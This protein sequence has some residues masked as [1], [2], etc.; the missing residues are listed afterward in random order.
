[1]RHANF[2][3]LKQKREIIEIE[4]YAHRCVRV[5][6]VGK[7]LK[8]QG[9]DLRYAFCSVLNREKTTPQPTGTESRKRAEN[10]SFFGYGF[11]CLLLFS[12]PFHRGYMAVFMTTGA[13][14][15]HTIL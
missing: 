15:N 7:G 12:I 1:M 13:R 6:G 10:T 11:L 3:M 8:I 9:S 14:V 4:N 2:R 5:S